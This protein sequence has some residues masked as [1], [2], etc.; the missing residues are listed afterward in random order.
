MCHF[1][2]QNRAICPQQYFFGT[3]H[4]YYFHLPIGPF[5]CAKL[6]KKSYSKSRVTRMLHFWA[7]NGSFESNKKRKKLSIIYLLAPFIL[8]N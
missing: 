2:A 1:W 8:Q 7:K 4:Y 6:K 3:N 5:H